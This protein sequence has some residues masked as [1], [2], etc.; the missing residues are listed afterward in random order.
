MKTLRPLVSCLAVLLSVAATAGTAANGEGWRRDRRGG[1]PIVT[2]YERPNFGGA[3]LEVQ[4]DET[5]LDFSL[6]RFPNGSRVDNKVSSI[7]LERG[8]Q[9]RI[10]ADDNFR[11][12][13]LELTRSVE[14]L[15][16]M[17]R[18]GGQTWNDAISS[19]RVYERRHGRQ[20]ERDPSRT[21]RIIVFARKDFGGE[22]FE[23]FPGESLDNLNRE[24]FESGTDLNDEISSIRVVGPLKVRLHADTKLRGETIEITADTSDMN[25]L[26]RGGG[27]KD[28]NDEASSLVVEWVGPPRK[29]DLAPEDD[30]D[31]NAGDRDDNRGGPGRGRNNQ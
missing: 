16:T 17:S 11:G 30:D 24:H 10:Y 26:R 13:F 23:I 9:M 7:H 28:W 27:R 25:N 3:S 6:L 5:I 18:A 12:E 20:Y 14:N 29:L 19:L 8:T 4:L 22:A 31:E 1:P 2:L 21:P 15:D